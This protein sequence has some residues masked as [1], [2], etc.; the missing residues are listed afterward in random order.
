MKR[1]QVLVF[2]HRQPP[3][4]YRLC[5]VWLL[6]LFIGL[7][8]VH[9]AGG[10]TDVSGIINTDTTWTAANSPYRVTGSITVAAGVTL[11]IQPGTRIE[12]SHYQGIYVDGILNAV[13][14]AA[15]P[16][17][18]TGTSETSN[19]WRGIQVHNAGSA[20]LEY[21]GVGF[22]G[23]YYAS[24]VLQQ[25]TGSLTLRNSEIH[26]TRGD[27]LRIAAGASFVTS[28]DNIYRDNTRGVRIGINASFDDRTSD[29][30][31]NSDA[32][33][34]VD[35]GTITGESTLGLKSDYSLFVSGSLVVGETGRLLVQPGTVMKFDHYKGLF[36]DGVL[37][38]PGLADAPV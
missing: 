29:F 12:A 33:V 14:T 15:L 17:V 10:Q 7:V 11:T 8:S 5:S 37:D 23:Y 25:G 36:I 4:Q 38:V 24:G 31:N 18:F 21:C 13:G 6:S 22:A 16:V 9:V 20:T 32:D 3:S 35:G 27:G 28:A 2:A 34:Y 26:D 19:W 1:S 30:M